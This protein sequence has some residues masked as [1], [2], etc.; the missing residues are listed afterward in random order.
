MTAHALTLVMTTIGLERF[1]AAQ[2]DE[3]VDLTISEVGVTPDA[4]VVAPTLTALPGEIRRIATVSGT[5]IG[6]NKVHLLVRDQA[7]LSYTV[8]GFGLYLADGTLFAVYGQEDPIVEKSAQSTA[9]LAIDIAFPTGDISDL[10]FGDTNF[11]NP[12][13]TTAIKGVVELA[14]NAEAMAGDDQERAITPAALKAAISA[15]IA[16]YDRIGTVKLWWGDSGDVAAGWAIC[17][18]QTVARSDGAGNITTP[19]LRGR[20]PVGADDTNALGVTF[21]ATSKTVSSATAGAH[22]HDVAI[23]AHDH[24]AGTLDATVDTALTGSTFTYHTKAD[25]ASGGTGKTLAVPPDGSAPTPP[26]IVDP[27]HAHGASISGTTAEWAGETVES[28]T[29]G[30]H[31]HDV[32]VDVTQPS[33]ALHFIMR[34]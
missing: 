23:P 32:T 3:D 27:G 29:G 2:L 7:E 14:T 1:T 6:D 17:N 30:D 19:D 16:A 10:T 33:I 24:G 9:L 4:F 20:V 18:G 26:A 28:S 11:L 8:R 31:D 5:Q 25:T 13:A 15:A 12:P 34:V 21:G 22:H